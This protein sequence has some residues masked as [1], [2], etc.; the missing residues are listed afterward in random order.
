MSCLVSNNPKTE[1]D[2]VNP[3]DQSNLSKD[4][5]IPNNRHRKE[6]ALWCFNF[7]KA[8]EIACSV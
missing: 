8:S 5:L 3:F 4:R 2:T 6:G 7:P 1:K